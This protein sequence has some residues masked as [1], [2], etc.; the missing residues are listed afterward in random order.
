MSEPERISSI[1]PRVMHHIWSRGT[2]ELGSRICR[3]RRCGARRITRNKQNQY[4]S[5]RTRTIS[6]TAPPCEQPAA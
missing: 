3:C 4:W 5:E 1:I 6:A 2:Y